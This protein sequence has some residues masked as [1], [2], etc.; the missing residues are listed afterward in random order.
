MAKQDYY[1]QLSVDRT[2]SSDEI[3]KAYRSLAMK[4]HPD[5]N[6]GDASAEHN[7][8]ELS[9]AYEVLKDQEKR[10]AYDQFGHAAFDGAGAGP[11]GGFGFTASSFADVFDDL[12]GEFMGG[13]RDGG[14]GQRG[15]DLRYNLEIS[16]ED[17]YRGKTASIRAATSVAC[18]A[19]AGS[20]AAHGSKPVSCPTC[21]GAGKV[22]VQQ[23]FFS[24][25]RTCSTCRGAGRVI[26]NPCRPC[27]GAGRVNKEKQLEVKI[28]KGVDGGMRIRL[29]NEGEAGLRGGP[30]GDLYI[31]LSVAPHQL[32]QRDGSN[33]YCKVP[34]PMTTA[35]LGGTVEV[36]TLDG[37]RARVTIPEGA[38]TGHQFRLRGKGMPAMR[39]GG[40]GDMVV[41]T[42][43]ETPVNLS[44]E[45]KEM[46]KSFAEAGTAE[47][48]PESEGFFSKVKELWEDLKD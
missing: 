4:Y 41:H 8:K 47:T 7:F 21:Q 31:F 45:Q 6:P 37:G 39:G 5:R 1:E 42:T 10:A 46:L 43:I 36:P 11:G 35:A 30:P 18:E 28:P 17:A 9:E 34:L 33:I 40:Y 20:G 3:K 24:I 22:R 44:D 25:E 19:C 38:Q 16:L 29:S 23:G 14:G 15:A 26:D 2:A 48:N 13:R 12:F 32:F 27:Q